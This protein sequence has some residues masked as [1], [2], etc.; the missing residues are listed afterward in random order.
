[1]NREI[2]NKLL[3]QEE[4]F[5]YKAFIGLILIIVFIILILAIGIFTIINC[6]EINK[7]E[8]KEIENRLVDKDFMNSEYGIRYKELLHKYLEDK[9]LKRYEHIEIEREW[10]EWDNK[11]MVV[12][13][14]IE[15]LGERK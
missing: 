14:L 7:E 12:E 1:M 5:N 13:R 3:M 10:Q 8:Y 2:I 4:V 11:R 15:R 9:K 6:L